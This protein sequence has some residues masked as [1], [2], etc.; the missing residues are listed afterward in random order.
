M[1]ECSRHEFTPPLELIPTGFQEITLRDCACDDG[2]ILW[3]WT[4]LS[5][6]IAQLLARASKMRKVIRGTYFLEP[7]CGRSVTSDGVEQR[8][9]ST[10]QY[11]VIVAAPVVEFPFDVFKKKPVV[12]VTLNK[13]IVMRAGYRDVL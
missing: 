5:Q 13:S 8:K 2:K 10:R 3:G 9:P 1:N 6:I 7:A 12:D 4:N 11:G